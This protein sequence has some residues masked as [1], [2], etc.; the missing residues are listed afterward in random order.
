M[1]PLNPDPRTCFVEDAQEETIESLQD[2]YAD[3]IEHVYKNL[4]T[5]H[6][7]PLWKKMGMKVKL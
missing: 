3:F 5:I 4:F 1:T 6:D 2:E 7:V